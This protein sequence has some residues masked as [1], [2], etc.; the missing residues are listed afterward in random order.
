MGYEPPVNQ[1]QPFCQPE[2]KNPGAQAGATGTKQDSPKV[3]EKITPS[4]PPYASAFLD[5]LLAVPAEDR[6]PFLEIFVEYYRTGP[7]GVT[8]LNAMQEARDWAR[9]ASIPDLKAYALAA[10][11]RLPVRAQ[12]SFVKHITEARHV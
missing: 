12:R 10:F 6:L 3:C 1:N 4:L 7:P 5:A 11:D 8:F 2:K 9:F